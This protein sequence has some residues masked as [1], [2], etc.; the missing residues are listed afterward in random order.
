MGSGLIT[1]IAAIL[2][3]GGIILF[4]ELGHFLVA[5]R[6]GVT[7]GEFSIGMGPV[8]FQREKNGTL[9]S[10][11]ALPIGGFVML[12]GEDEEV[13]SPGSFSSKP[14][15]HR[16]AILLAGSGANLLMGYLLLVLLT[17]M[18]GYVGTTYVVEFNEGS[19]SQAFLQEGDRITRVNG[20][21]VRT[22]NDIVYEFL[23]D[24]DGLIEIDLVREG[25]SI[26]LPVQFEMEQLEDGMQSINI[27]FKVAAFPAKPLQYL[28]YPFNWGLSIIK[29]VWGS[30]IDLLSGRVAVNQ[31]S[32][33]VGVVNAIG[34]AS[35]M[36]LTQVLTMAAF[37]AINIG[38]FNLL[39]IPILDGGK[40]LIALIEGIFHRSINRRVIEW[41]MTASVMFMVG[42]ML[43]VTWNDIFRLV[44]N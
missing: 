43:Y 20:H 32:G 28:T 25:E 4:H 37:I 21:R 2:I 10:V 24:Q 44:A 22:S 12:E 30:L 40:I 39:P 27:D 29:Q 31:L 5:K 9:Y 13:D 11:R 16:I 41:T 14:I 6:A 8:L 7:V 33:P 38:V 3:F 34:Q 26:H 19:V 15:L 36:G 1:A 35:Q 17:A 18:S 42:L 23:R